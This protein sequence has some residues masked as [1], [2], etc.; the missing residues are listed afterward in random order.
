[1]LAPDQ[2]CVGGGIDVTERRVRE[3]TYASG[4]NR[5]SL[6]LDLERLELAGLEGSVSNS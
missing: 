4:T 3:G 5:Q 2:R 6:P 1:M